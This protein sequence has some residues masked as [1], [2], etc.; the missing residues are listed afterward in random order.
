MKTIGIIGGTSWESTVTY[1]QIMNERVK[2]ACGG[3][4]SAKLLLYSVNFAEVE[5]HMSAGEWDDVARILGDAA[6][7]L[8]K[9]GADF[10][11][12]ATNTLHIVIDSIASRVSIPFIHIADATADAIIEKGYKKVALL[13]TRFTMTEGFIKDRITA[14]GIEVLVPNSEAITRIDDIIFKELCLGIIKEESRHYYESVIED[15]KAAGAEGVILGCTEI[16]M[17]ISSDNSA[18]PVFDTAVIHPEAAVKAALSD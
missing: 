7:R 9:G 17:L 8:E 4:S 15:M 3:L 18:L 6:V 10:I 16:G 13:G 5:S 1:Y 14:R 11:V 12:L 2:E